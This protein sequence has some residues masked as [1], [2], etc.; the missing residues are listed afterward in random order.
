MSY[1]RGDTAFLVEEEPLHCEL[2]GAFGELR[3]YGPGG[4][5]ICYDCGM[6]PENKQKV[7]RHINEILDG[8]GLAVHVKLPPKQ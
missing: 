8:A 4:K 3:P 7:E 5:R 1:R 2:C 6:K